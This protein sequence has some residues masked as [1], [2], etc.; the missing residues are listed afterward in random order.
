VQ[1]IFLTRPTAIIKKIKPGKLLL[2]LNSGE[3][4]MMAKLQKLKNVKAKA[5]DN[6]FSSVSSSR[7]LFRTIKFLKT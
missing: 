4:T 3:N 2:N 5:R 6:V 7:H 1:T